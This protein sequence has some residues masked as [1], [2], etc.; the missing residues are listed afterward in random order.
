MSVVGLVSSLICLAPL[1][2]GSKLET[3][4]TTSLLD[5]ARRAAAAAAADCSCCCC[6]WPPF[7]AL[8]TLKY[9]FHQL[10]NFRQFVYLHSRKPIMISLRP[11]T[12]ITSRRSIQVARAGAASFSSSSACA[13]PKT[14]PGRGKCFRSTIFVQNTDKNAFLTSCCFLVPRWDSSCQP[15]RPQRQA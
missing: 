1:N 7:V 15:F 3:K 8:S 14:K 9:E 5:F 2:G 4:N 11:L 13:S 6:C 12:S 10:Y